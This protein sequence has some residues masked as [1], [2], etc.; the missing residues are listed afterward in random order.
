MPN[1]RIQLALS[2]REIR[3]HVDRTDLYLLLPSRRAISPP[4]F[5]S[6]ALRLC[7]HLPEKERCDK[8]TLGRVENLSV[9]SNDSQGLASV[10]W[11]NGCSEDTS[12]ISERAPICSCLL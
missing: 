3:P 4:H 7:R 1:T 11:S 5:L 2:V 10:A 6:R 9:S 12:Q 8:T